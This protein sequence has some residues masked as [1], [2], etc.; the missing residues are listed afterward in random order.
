MAKGDVTEVGVPIDSARLWWFIRARRKTGA[1]ATMRSIM[2]QEGYNAALDD[3]AK[4][5]REGGY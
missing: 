1:S 4:W 5:L 2:R 3:L